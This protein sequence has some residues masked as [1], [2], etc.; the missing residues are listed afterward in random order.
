[1]WILIL[2]RRYRMGLLVRKAVS[3]SG[4]RWVNID[5]YS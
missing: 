1:M 3:F 2:R 4:S 5:S